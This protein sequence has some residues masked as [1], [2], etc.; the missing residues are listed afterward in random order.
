MVYQLAALFSKEAVGL[1]SRSRPMS[2]LT[3]R[4]DLNSDKGIVLCSNLDFCASRLAKCLPNVSKRVA[5]LLQPTFLV[6]APVATLKS[7]F[8]KF[9]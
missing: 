1:M 2:A 5:Q 9:H 8:F 3:E 6:V 7:C 4:V